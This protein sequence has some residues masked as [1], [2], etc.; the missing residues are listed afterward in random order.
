MNQVP[1]HHE[2]CHQNRLTLIHQL[3]LVA[4]FHPSAGPEVEIY[5]GYYISGL[6]SWSSSQ[7]THPSRLVP[8]PCSLRC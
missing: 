6:T 2:A 7:V 8:G 4:Q 1:S 3:H 5:G